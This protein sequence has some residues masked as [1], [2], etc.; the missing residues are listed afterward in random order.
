MLTRPCPHHAHPHPTMHTPSTTEEPLTALSR[1]W[2]TKH[3]NI[4]TPS[5]CLEDQDPRDTA[6]LGGHNQYW[7]T[8][9]IYTLLYSVQYKLCIQEYGSEIL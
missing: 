2:T 9:C 6:G 1:L 5:L 7:K 4:E 3:R 8:P